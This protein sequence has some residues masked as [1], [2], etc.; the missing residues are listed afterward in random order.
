MVQAV[1]LAS[2]APDKLAQCYDRLVSLCFPE[3]EKQRAIRERLARMGF[4]KV[5]DKTF[6]LDV[7]PSGDVKLNIGA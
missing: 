2:A 4:E 1:A 7:Q 3:V 5:K 6:K